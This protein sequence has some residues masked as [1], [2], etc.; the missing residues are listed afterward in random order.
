MPTRRRSSY[1]ETN[2]NS[3][4]ESGPAVQPDAL[5]IELVDVGVAPALPSFSPM[6]AKDGTLRAGG[7]SDDAESENLVMG[8]SAPP[9]RR[10][11]SGS[12][13]TVADYMFRNENLPMSDSDTAC[14]KPTVGLVLRRGRVIQAREFHIDAP[15]VN[16]IRN[17][18]SSG[19]TL[20]DLDEVS[21]LLSSALSSLTFYARCL[22]P[23]LLTTC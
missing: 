12:M 19:A 11:R 6:G 7:E 5:E 8:N 3:S 16:I 10:S 15:H 13:H 22:R 1:S 23:E 2:S 17:L 4:P 20:L 21:N 9:R 14:D 18:F